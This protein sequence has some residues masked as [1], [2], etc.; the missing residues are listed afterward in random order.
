MDFCKQKTGA[1]PH[2]NDKRKDAPNR[3]ALLLIDPFAS[4]GVRTDAP[5]FFVLRGYPTTPARRCQAFFAPRANLG[6]K[7]FEKTGRSAG[8]NAGAAL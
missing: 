4:L 7:F 2:P 8:D 5:F 3:A 1:E 6:A